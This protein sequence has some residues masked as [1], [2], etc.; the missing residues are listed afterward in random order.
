MRAVD[1]AVRGFP[2]A[3]AKLDVVAWAQLNTWH[4]VSFA[5]A[6]KAALLNH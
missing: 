2:L 6:V 4:R 5:S 1:D 3:L